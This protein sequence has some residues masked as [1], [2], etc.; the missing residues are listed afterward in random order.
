MSSVFSL[1]ITIS[2]NS[3]CFTGDG[4]P[5]NQR[6]GRRHTYKSKICLSATF[7]ERIPPPIGVVKGPLI[8]TKNS[9]H[10]SM[11]SSGNQFPVSW[12]AFSPAYTSSHFISFF[13]R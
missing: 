12:F 7:N 11:V 4:T 2:I 13:P 5:L 9:L 3:G 8:A 10:A 6:T 1:K